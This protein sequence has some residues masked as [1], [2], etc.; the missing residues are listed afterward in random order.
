MVF[1]AGLPQLVGLAGKAK[2]YAER[3]FNYPPIGALPA[4]DAAEALN[5]QSVGEHSLADN[6]FYSGITTSGGVIG[7]VLQNGYLTLPG[8][9]LL[10]TG[11][12]GSMVLNGTAISET[13]FPLLYLYNGE[14]ELVPEP[15]TWAMMLGG[16]ALLVLIQHRRRQNK[17]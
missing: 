1:G 10:T 5:K 16:L 17:N 13:Y 9:G 2:S 3:L 6:N 15:S 12:V 7:G 14:L 8:G 4:G 11:S